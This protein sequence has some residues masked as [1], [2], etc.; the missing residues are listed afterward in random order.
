LWLA[1][2][3]DEPDMPKLIPLLLA[4]WIVPLVAVWVPASMAAIPAAAPGVTVAVITPLLRPKD[5]PLE[6]EK[7]TVPVE[8]DEVPPL[9]ATPPP[10]PGLVLGGN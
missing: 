2:I 1:V 9:I 3:W 4:N 5:T 7:T 6:L 8:A 10:P